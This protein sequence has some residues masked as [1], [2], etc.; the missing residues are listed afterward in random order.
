M[1]KIFFLFPMLFISP[2]LASAISTDE[3]KKCKKVTESSKKLDCYE[4]LYSE[5]EIVK[6]EKND[7][8]ISQYKSEVDDSQTV[9][10]GVESSRPIHTTL[11][12][13]ASPR[14]IIR[15][16]NKKTEI[17]INWGAYLGIDETEVTTRI[18]Q[19]KAAKKWWIISTD[20]KSA[21]YPDGKI[22]FIK[23]LF[24]KNKLFAQVTPYGE[25]TINTTFNV[26][27]LSDEIAPVR[28]SCGW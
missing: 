25:N 10:L 11:L 26:T 12:G 20:N 1:K 5:K 2:A 17:Y 7:W 19:E 24:G 15:C 22:A 8:H 9:I 13:V 3:Y 14:L 28:K 16:Q 4:S 6:K 18:N 23:S 27:G 21:F